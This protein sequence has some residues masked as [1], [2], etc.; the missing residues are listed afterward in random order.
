MVFDPLFHL[1]FEP[2][3]I[4]LPS[5]LLDWMNIAINTLRAEPGWLMALIFLVAFV[6]AFALVGLVVPGIVLLFGLSVAI[7]LDPMLFVWAWVSA[8]AGAFIGDSTSFAL[9]RRWQPKRY[10]EVVTRAQALF[11]RHG[12]KSI[13]IG[14][15]IGP[16][17]PVIPMVGGMLGMH[18]PT[19]LKF[20]IPACVLWAPVYL[21]PGMIFGA[22]LE[23]AAAMAGRLAVVMVVVVMGTWFGLWLVRLVYG[24]SAKKSSWWIKRWVQWSHRH[25]ILGGWF[26]DLTRPGSREVIAMV[27]LGLVLAI[28]LSVL[29][30]LLFL[31]PSLLPQW[32]VPFHPATWASSLRNEW[33]DPIFV[34]VSLIGD[35]SVLSLLVVIMT[36]SFMVGRRWMAAGHWV[37]AV[38]GAWLLAWGI[39]GLMG[40]VINQPPPASVAHD[41]LT[42][43]PHREFALLVTVVGFFALMVAKDMSARARKW[44]YAIAA[45]ILIPTGFSYFYLELASIL[46]LSTALALGVG[47]TALVGMGYRHR[48]RVRDFPVRMLM[49]FFGAW[50]LLAGVHVQQEY[51]P[52]LT[53]SEVPI[54][55]Q[56]MSQQRWL[57]GGWQSLPDRR[58]LL[59]PE[60]AQSIDFQ[61]AAPLVHAGA[62]NGD[63]KDGLLAQL[64]AQGW[65]SVP[66]ISWRG[67]LMGLNQSPMHWPRAL[68]GR[69][70]AILM[71]RTQGE[72]GQVQVLRLWDSGLL[73]KTDEVSP[74]IPVWLGQARAVQLERGLLGF[75]RWRDQPDSSPIDALREQFGDDALIL[76]R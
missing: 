55:P 50:V 33:A 54:N 53:Q 11:Q 13:F 29:I 19:F 5:M 18:W 26:R 68:N 43:L 15:F 1:S 62:G 44:P 49:V 75:R 34:V 7:G 45:F 25:R 71:T 63:E 27:F 66:P 4:I 16:V 39:D 30:V 28:S 57:A 35:V 37:V 22:S 74:L 65:V 70:E 42:D 2:E 76:M 47:W 14:R 12:G 48:T 20:A 32:S 64:E 10:G 51:E 46:G 73:L 52:R 36:A 41:S 3:P 60:I 58:S 24:M 72:T 23:M 67:V 8:S 21:L 17:R 31:A 59:G 6:E 40:V 69:S 61:L 9:G 38:V 56:V